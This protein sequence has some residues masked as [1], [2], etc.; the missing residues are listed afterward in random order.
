MC[1]CMCMCVYVCRCVCMR[2]YGCIPICILLYRNV[3]LLLNYIVKYIMRLTSYMLFI[4]LL[5]YNNCVHLFN[6]T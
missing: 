4:I 3:Y 5:L 1:V 2:V 6:I